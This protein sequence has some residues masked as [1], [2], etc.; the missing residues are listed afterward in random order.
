MDG[1]VDVALGGKM[2]DR[3]RLVL[4]QQLRDQLGVAD[5]AVDEGMALV[6]LD[7]RQV[8][9]VAGVGQL[10]EIDDG[11]VLAGQ[12]VKDKIGAYESRA[13]CYQYHV[14]ALWNFLLL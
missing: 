6:S 3:A 14:I 12:P 1:S 8:A 2:H 5:V 7:S 9:E 4:R 11:L 13:A 10:V